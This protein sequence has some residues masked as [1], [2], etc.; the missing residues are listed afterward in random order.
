MAAVNR[1]VDA[2]RRF[3]SLAHVGRAA[4]GWDVEHQEWG[5]A[6]SLPDLAD[7]MV[8]WLAG[9]LQT[10]PGYY[11]P[12]DLD[13]PELTSLCVDLCLNGFVTTDSQRA[14]V[15]VNHDGESVRSRA[16]VSGFC[17]DVTIDRIHAAARETGLSVIAQRGWHSGISGAVVV[18]EVD[19]APYYFAGGY[20]SRDDLIAGWADVW[21]REDAPGLR[22]GISWRAFRAIRSA[23]YVSIIDSEWG[24]NDR[25]VSALTNASKPGWLS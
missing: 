2:L 16:M 10:R 12:S 18:T 5:K 9:D 19:G 6:R 8:R 21:R 7:L 14:V 13:T 3:G 15:T 1:W 24:R 22:L 11:G 25:L 23:W 20:P 4:S 17:G